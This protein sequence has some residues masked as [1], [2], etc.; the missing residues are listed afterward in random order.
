MRGPKTRAGFP[1]IGIGLAFDALEL[2]NHRR[3]DNSPQ[4]RMRSRHRP[5]HIEALELRCLMDAAGGAASVSAMWFEMASNT[6]GIAHVGTATWT[7]QGITSQATSA[8]NLDDKVYDWIVQFDTASLSGIT[9][10]AQTATLLAGNGVNF[11]VICGLGLTGMVLVRSF[12]ASFQ[13]VESCLAADSD[14]ACY[15]EDAVRQFDV[16]ASDPDYKDL[17][18]LDQIDASDAWN[19]TTG[20]R[21]VVVA[22]LDSGV[23]Y[24]HA[25]LAA[26]IWTN[27]NAGSDG[28]SG[29]LHGYD[30]A[31]GDGD[32]MDDNGHG[33]HVAGI[34]AAVGSNGVGVTG[35]NWSA[36]LMCLKFLDS[37]GQGYL[38]DAL[39]AVNYVTMQHN[40]YNVNVHV[41]NASWGGTEYSAALEA[42]ID[43]AGDAGILFVTAA[44]NTGS[45]N[46]ATAQ[47]PANYSCDN[48]ITVA[49]STRSDKL[50]SFSSY[51]ATS[52]DIAAP[53]VSIYST[54][55]GGR[56]GALSGT[57]MATPYVS[58][59]AALAWAVDSTA[60]VAEVRNAILQGVDRISSLS[61][62]VASGGRL[63]AYNTLLIISNGSAQGTTPDTTTTSD[64]STIGLYDSSVATFLLKNS[65]SAGAANLSFTYGA[66]SS[67]LQILV[68][69]WDGDGTDTIGVYDSTTSTFYLRNS[70]SSGYANLVISFGRAHSGWTAI[71]G[72]WNGDG[73][74]TIGLYDPTRSM[75]FLRNSNT[76]GCAD[77]SLSFGA[78]NSGWTTLVG[79]WNGDGKDTVGLYDSTN[80]RFFLRNSNTT[81]YADLAFVYGAAHSGW[82]AVA[83]DWNGDG[84]DTIGL[85]DPTQA[86]FFLRNANASGYAD[87]AFSYGAANGAYT[88]L[89][90]NW[91][92]SE[93]AS[94]S[95]A[96]LLESLQSSAFDSSDTAGRETTVDARIEQIEAAISGLLQSGTSN[97]DWHGLGAYR[98]EFCGTDAD[99]AATQRSVVARS[100][101][102][103]GCKTRL[104]DLFA[105]LD[106]QL[107]DLMNDGSEFAELSRL[108]AATDATLRHTA[109]DA[110]SITGG[111]FD[112]ARLTTSDLIELHA[113]DG[114][115]DLATAVASV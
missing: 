43:A 73:K 60:T 36:S 55:P 42:A 9:S 91:D 70:N 25:D 112:A 81:G 61:G 11:E 28:F 5:L 14:V 95:A 103:D 26:N 69:D 38:S 40:V 13:T 107:D 3:P 27:A 67:G 23:D 94:A 65:N 113:I 29:D 37:N 105:S 24:T 47:Y 97:A 45:N 74:D 89:A 86:K 54:L 100:F 88:P 78:A 20:S 50:A 57:S 114:D 1:G 39:R 6:T 110:W 62:K 92:S 58:A 49:A 52:V 75:F 96:S 56:Y 82:K 87:A 79:D 41:I 31:N 106:R 102:Y 77:L 66:A 53:G 48:I 10:V 32:P 101:S 64:I 98:D 34:I 90:G 84:K 12:D 104:D 111:L 16:T 93:S 59:V 71:A 35:A 2:I 21:S 80:G 44:G 115:P 83:G 109:D 8:S 30:F 85:Y 7:A 4:A 68:G 17:W 76:S 63:N 46:D 18:G 72:D 108:K 33:T 99:T 51:G 15:E 19:I 22:V